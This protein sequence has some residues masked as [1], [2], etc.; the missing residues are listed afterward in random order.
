[1]QVQ[2][3]YLTVLTA[4]LDRQTNKVTT[5]MAASIGVYPPEGEFNVGI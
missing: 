1:M 4:D 5:D 2:N 3:A